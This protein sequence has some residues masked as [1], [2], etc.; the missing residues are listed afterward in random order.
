M[1]SNYG[2]RDTVGTQYIEAQKSPQLTLGE[3]NSCMVSSLVEDLNK[4]IES[5]PFQGRPFYINV[6][7][8]RDLQMPNSFKR[9]MFVSIYRPYPEDNTLVFHVDHKANEVTFCW[10]LPHHSELLNIMSNAYL[11]DFEYI[12]QIQRWLKNDLS[13]FG[14]VKVHIDNSSIEGYKAKTVNAYREAYLN[15]C[16]NSGMNEKQI[17]SERRLGFFWLP[18]LKFKDQSLK[19]KKHSLIIA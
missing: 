17:E 11:Y 6:V 5:N 1:K 12:Q 10:D 16:K 18:S 13:G 15:Q 8:E 3:I 7:E 9:R 2:D 4:T 19:P 14:F